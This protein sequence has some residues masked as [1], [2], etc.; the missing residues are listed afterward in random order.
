MHSVVLSNSILASWICTAHSRSAGVVH[1]LQPLEEDEVG[2][3]LY[4]GERISDAFR[5]E[6]VPEGVEFTS[7]LGVGGQAV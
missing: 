5:P 6:A 3:L 1:I 2:Y 4:G 7:E